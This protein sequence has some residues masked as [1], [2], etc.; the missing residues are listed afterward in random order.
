MEAVVLEQNWQMWVTFGIVLSGVALYAFEKFSIELTSAGILAIL[1]VF[2][3]FFAPE[4]STNL[5]ARSL[6]SGFSDPALITIMALL[7]IGQ[8][9]FQTG[10]LETTT[11]ILSGYLQSCP[12]R[13]MFFVFTFAFVISM[14]MNNTPV[15][16]MFIPILASMALQIR[17]APSRYM[18]PLSFICILAGMTTLVGSSTNILVAGTLDRMTNTTLE[19]FDPVW[20]GILLAL[21]GAV[22]IV[23]ASKW[24]LPQRTLVLNERKHS[25]QQYIAQIRI[26]EKHPLRGTVPIAGLFPDLRTMTVRMIMRNEQ[27]LLPPFESALEAEDV[28]TVS[29]TRRAL[30]KLLSSHPEYLE[31][32]LSISGFR[33]SPNQPQARMAIS[34]AMIAPGSRLV[35]QTI[36]RAGFRRQTGCLVLGIERRSHMIRDGM[37]NIRLQPSDVLLLFG[38]VPEIQAL[39]DNR[40]IILLD[41]ATRDLPDIRRANRARLIFAGVILLAALDILPIVHASFAGAT[42]MLA[43]GCLNIRQAARAFNTKVFMLVGA[44]FAMGIA[45]EETGGASYVAGSVVNLLQGFGPQIL[46]AGLFLLVAVMTN[47]LSN[48]ATAILFAPIAV[49][50]SAQTG[51]D[52]K[53]MILTVLFA[54]NCSFATPIAYQTNLLV[55]GPGHYRFFDFC[56]FGIPLIL[57]LWISYILMLPFVFDP[58]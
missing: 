12:K 22:Y 58:L 16:V 27:R 41:W 33:K 37:L 34:E 49:N 3:Q 9:I 39:R 25:G 35:G 36:E 46:I 18:M 15:V 29:T 45:L 17:S 14:F 24:L 31:G 10:A 2:F 53:I 21:I 38:Y 47:L 40:D 23:L 54:A 26:T 57:L 50:V 8:G 6:F 28:L 43:T 4:Y 51:I 5:N 56:R 7:V 11:R 19:F 20:P 13:T 1:V 52:P 48:S 44:A 32:M 30:E 42:L 55:L